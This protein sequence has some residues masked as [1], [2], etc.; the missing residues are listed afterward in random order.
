MFT[1]ILSLGYQMG[2]R[3]FL[4]F[5]S[6]GTNCTSYCSRAGK[7]WCC[8]NDSES[9]YRP[10]SPGQGNQNYWHIDN[11]P[12]VLKN[13][14]GL[15]QNWRLSADKSPGAC[16]HYSLKA[17]STMEDAR[18]LMSL[19]VTDTGN[20]LFNVEWVLHDHIDN[21]REQRTPQKYSVGSQLPM[22]GLSCQRNKSEP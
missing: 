5:S 17:Q 1:R 13:L 11:R 7:G 15:Y 22:L 20:N 10:I 18:W 21:W 3:H 12:F 14:I 4:V 19:K 6:E 16:H 8:G 9:W 2:R